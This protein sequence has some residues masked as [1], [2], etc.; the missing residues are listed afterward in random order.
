M[1]DEHTRRLLER[2]AGPLPSAPPH[3]D[4]EARADRLRRRR[5]LA[6]SSGAT[7]LVVA[8]IVGVLGVAA[9]VQRRQPVI[10]LGGVD[11]AAETGG[12]AVAGGCTEPAYRPGYLPWLGAGADVPPP[13]AVSRT[14]SGTTLHW[15]EGHGA[16]AS[17]VT[18]TRRHGT[19]SAEDGPYVPGGGRLRSSRGGHVRVVWNLGRS[20][21][22]VL[23]LAFTVPSGS[24]D[25]EGIKRAAMGIALSLVTPDG[26]PFEIANPEICPPPP[27]IPTYLP[28]LP[29]G[30]ALPS[31]DVSYWEDAPEDDAYDFGWEAR[32]TGR[33]SI[34]YV[35]MARFSQDMVSDGGEPAGH[36]ILGSEGVLSSDE[37]YSYIGWDLDDDYCNAITLT[38]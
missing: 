21:C 7:A 15:N 3:G 13:E 17:T 24:T 19:V 14:S 22:N 34:A 35:V 36:E 33:D 26:R 25:G 6:V 18:V 23:E 27:V 28:W 20:R 10:A 9:S 30:K 16:D 37:T 38:S 5:R 4:I 31:P 29:E 2:G 1:A 32:D 8:V 12:R 11:R